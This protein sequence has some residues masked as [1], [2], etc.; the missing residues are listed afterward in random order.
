MLNSRLWSLVVVWLRA[1]FSWAP[2]NFVA[3]F[4]LDKACSVYKLLYTR[5]LATSG[6]GSC[7]EG[8][9]KR[10][11]TFSCSDE[12]TFCQEPIGDRRFLARKVD[13]DCKNPVAEPKTT[14]QL[15][16]YWRRLCSLQ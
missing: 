11:D 13:L 5:G 2:S 4:W 8:G 6:S 15:L 9:E 3:H 10:Q 14:A 12:A 1:F 16:F 7:V